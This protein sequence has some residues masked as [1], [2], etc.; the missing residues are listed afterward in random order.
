MYIH[1]P[2]N[3]MFDYIEVYGREAGEVTSI[4]FD[5]RKSQKGAA[6]FCMK[7]LN[8]DGEAFIDEALHKGSTGIVSQNG[9]R[10]KELSLSYPDLTFIEVL[11]TRTAAA[12]FSAA[13]YHNSSRDLFLT[14]VTG[15]NGKTTV[16]SYIRSILNALGMPAGMIGTNGIWSSREKLSFR[17]STPTT[18]EAPD[19]HRIFSE[20]AAHGEKA[21]VME[22]SSIALD[23]KR[24]EG[25]QFDVAVHTNLSPEH[26]EYHKTF[27]NYREAKL[28]LFKQ[29]DKAV[30]NADDVLGAEILSVFPG[31]VLTYSLNRDVEADIHA[32]AITPS[33]TGTSAV[34]EMNGQAQHVFLPLFGE[35]NIAN[36]LAAVCTA[37]HGGFSLSHVLEAAEKIEPV[38]GRFQVV[39]GK[40]KQKIIIDYA[41][42]PTALDQLLKEVKKQ[43][44]RR[45]I[46]ML[47]GIGIRDFSKMPRMAA[48]AE[49]RADQIVVSVDH[50]GDHEPQLVIDQVLSGFRNPE[51]PSIS[52]ALNREEA[53]RK[54]LSLSSEGDIVLLT[55]GCINGAQ[56]VKGQSIP[57][58]D[59]K[60]IEEY[61]EQ[62][63]CGQQRS[64]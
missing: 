17:G 23:Q 18:P 49:G 39:W 58:S 9:K 35:Y 61:F 22:V 37:L 57:H 53:V 64:I 7:G 27:E 50:P 12:Q 3:K 44:G 42:T 55:S 5:S 1:F 60:V 6:F 63:G 62:N 40:E 15:T 10:M 56:I 2:G 47:M 16:A 21:A 4:V 29:A 19:L 41:H 34:I 32:Y 13:F 45:V 14:G 8:Q 25:I 48:T 46:L 30:V 36:I 26:M 33:E 20:Y 28:K 24:V 59:E 43:K 31:R 54:A 51:D 38:E 11:N 52:T